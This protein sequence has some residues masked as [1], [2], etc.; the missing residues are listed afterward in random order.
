MF[1]MLLNVLTAVE[2]IE[3]S[4]LSVWTVSRRDLAL[5]PYF[6]GNYGNT[7]DPSWSVHSHTRQ[8]TFLRMTL[9]SVR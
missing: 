2:D 1:G 6:S 4:G 9:V 8:F 5:D 3:L 7:T